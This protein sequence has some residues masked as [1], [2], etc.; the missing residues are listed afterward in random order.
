[1]C[2]RRVNLPSCFA[3]RCIADPGAFGRGA[4]C[5][6]RER[7]PKDAAEA[8]CSTG[9]GLASLTKHDPRRMIGKLS[10]AVVEGRSIRMAGPT[11]SFMGTFT[12]TKKKHS[13]KNCAILLDFEQLG[14]I[15]SSFTTEPQPCRGDGSYFWGDRNKHVFLI[16]P[17]SLGEKKQPLSVTILDDS[18]GKL[19]E[20]GKGRI[21]LKDIL[22]S[23]V[24]SS[25][26]RCVRS[27]WPCLF[28]PFSLLLAVCSHKCTQS[29]CKM[30][31][32][33][34]IRMKSENGKDVGSIRLDLHFEGG[35]PHTPA[36]LIYA[37][38]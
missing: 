29:G 22:R 31:E 16:D 34:W 2:G 26:R 27:G 36:I 38:P 1:M 11:F 35:S 13:I 8:Y 20:F 7:C 4:N 30:A 37:P 28:I 19:L 23:H 33:K 32:T 21:D 10:I 9:W 3:A 6:A 18:S 24:L 5:E 14:S 12:K 25:E 17:T 15:G